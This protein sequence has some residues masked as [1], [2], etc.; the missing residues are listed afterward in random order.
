MNRHALALAATC[1]ALASSP[2]FADVLRLKNGDIFTG[3]ITRHEGGKVTLKGDLFGEI[4]VNE[5]DVASFKVGDGLTASDLEAAPAATT[6]AVPVTAATASAGGSTSST[7]SGQAGNPNKAAWSR[8]FTFGGS[9]V[10]P[11]FEQGQIPGT[12]PGTT[13]AALRLPGRVL[14]FQAS[15]S[16]VR[17]TQNDA[18]SLD[19][20]Y[21]YTDY[22]PNG[23]QTDNYSAAFAWNHKLSDRTYTSSRTSYSV[24]TVKNIDYSAVQL[25]GFG[26]KIKDTVQT[27]LDIVPG[28]ILSQEKKGNQYDDDLM[29]G[30]GFLQNFT[31]FFNQ[32]ASMEQRILYRQSFEET[33]VYAVDAYIGFK[34]MLSPRMGVT[35]GVLYL[36]DNTLGPVSFPFGGTTVTLQAQNKDQL[37]IQSGIQYKF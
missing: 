2:A 12:P 5:T 29:V 9:Y 19:L 8:T 1:L 33:D 36:Y 13:G 10:S 27:K 23:R 7:F 16:I 22:E 31:Y 37:S 32:Y 34:G 11:T 18:H 3:K 4:T 26:Y 17:T 30:G 6:A 35:I 15:A 28:I 20:T 14:G 25:L 24:D 21:N